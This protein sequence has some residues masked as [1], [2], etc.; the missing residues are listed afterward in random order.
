MNPRYLSLLASFLTPAFSFAAAPVTPP[1]LV[2]LAGNYQ[3]LLYTGAGD[4]GS[5]TAFVTLAVTN[6]GALTGKLTTEENKTYAFKSSLTYAEGVATA[7]P[8]AISRGKAPI[9][10][11][12]LALSVH[13]G[14]V[15]TLSVN[16]KLGDEGAAQT[17]NGFKL[18][19]F[20]KGDLADEAAGTYT[21]AFELADSPAE[22][23]PA[24]SGYA[25]VSVDAK[26]LLKLAGKTGD[27][28][29]I[30]ASLP[31]GPDHRY[32]AY[33]NPYKRVSSLFAGKITL[34]ARIGGGF[35]V[36]PAVGEGY[37]FQWKKSSLLP[38]TTDKSYRGGF[39]PLD[40][41]LTMEPWKI[42]AKGVSVASLFGIDATEVFE[43]A[44]DGEFSS[45]S[46]L[47][48]IPVK[49]GLTAQDTLRIAAGG[50]GNLNGFNPA[51]WAKTLTTK[52][53]P[54][55]GKFTAILNIEDS[56]D[57]G[58]KSKIVKRKVP[59]EGVLLQTEAG[60]S[61]S[62]AQGQIL[63]PPVDAKTETTTSTMF[64]FSGTITVD[65]VYA[66]A[67]KTAGTYEATFIRE[68]NED[69]NG[70]LEF[71]YAP[72]APGAEA[73]L[74]FT[75]APDLQSMVFNGRE[76]PLKTDARYN[77]QMVYESPSLF[78][79]LYV[80]ITLDPVTRRVND[81]PAVTYKVMSGI[82][83]KISNFVTKDGTSVTKF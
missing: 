30:T 81:V 83:L 16:L 67:A 11:W 47:K 75:I 55:T 5:P 33:L 51:L 78:N 32:V 36:L 40:V 14:D 10:A 27:G 15:D 50:T 42:P 54:K 76:V 31:V 52:I 17:L 48:D 20:A 71:P 3:A 56:V 34:T 21:A 28:T 61:A 44:Y 80:L 4:T 62:I 69:K 13:D 58:G 70:K 59:F 72:G 9:A 53:D 79:S 8:V 2:N 41:L 77:N 26:G 45:T 7:A 19:T 65:A 25:T 35:H 37:D 74:K 63:V 57:V 68:S 46:H 73:K 12:N 22:D 64:A 18:K 49:A 38:K 24:G 1:E 39:G 23:E 6:K 60:S 29:V 66:E 43:I 82:G